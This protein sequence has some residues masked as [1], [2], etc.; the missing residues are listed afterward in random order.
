MFPPLYVIMDAA[1]CSS[2][3][4]RLARELAAAGV[5][6]IQYR[7]KTATS[8]DLYR[9]CQSLVEA[10]AGSRTRLIVN[11]RVDVAVLCGAGGVH[12][13]QEDLPVEAARRLL[14]SGGWIGLSTHTLEQL[15]QA[16][17]TTADYVAYGPIFPTRTKRA[18]EAPVGIEGLLAARQRTRRPLVAIGGITLERAEALWRAGAD[19]VAVA[20][21]ILT[22][23]DPPARARAFLELAAHCR[24][25]TAS[26]TETQTG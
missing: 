11:D 16:E 1:L 23:A 3:P 7:D 26:A 17:R 21:D 18:A 12:L 6:L 14:G 22:A 5:E 2:P 25:G 20:A 24:A 8:A 9:V 19:A 4:P 15:T 13:G 10:L